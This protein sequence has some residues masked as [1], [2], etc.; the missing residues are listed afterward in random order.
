MKKSVK[1]ILV[2]VCICATV[3]VLLA[4]TNYVTAPIVKENEEKKVTASLLE[5][6]PDGEN[7]ESIDI[8]KYELPESVSA[9]YRAKSGGYVVKLDTKGYATGM[10]IL[11][12]ISG[13]GKIVG[14]KMVS[15]SETPSIG[16][17]AADVF[18]KNVIGKDIN[19]VSEVDTVAGA[20][21]TT[22]AYRTALKDAL[23]TVAD[24]SKGEVK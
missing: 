6:L 2:L 1:S 9:V 4:L 7:F 20:T 17:K 10:V 23:Q 15:S 3:S 24:I 8:S 11:C 18:A 12:G 14:T 22:E 16:G 5:V 21:K 19:N 13:E